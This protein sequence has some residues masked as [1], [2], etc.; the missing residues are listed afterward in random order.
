MKTKQ[1]QDVLRY[2]DQ[3]R[4]NTFEPVDQAIEALNL[5]PLRFRKLNGILGALIM[6]IEDGG[7]SPE[8]NELLVKALRA[9]IIFQ[10]GE[11]VAKPALEALARFEQSEALRLGGKKSA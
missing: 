1:P 4:L 10:V 6:Q 9:A 11:A 5:P 8:V 7:D 3:A 2:I